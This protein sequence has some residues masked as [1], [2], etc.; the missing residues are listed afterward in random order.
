MNPERY[1]WRRGSA[2]RPGAPAAF[3]ECV[4]KRHRANPWPIALIA[5]PHAIRLARA[6]A[7][8]TDK[9]LRRSIVELVEELAAEDRSP[10][11]GM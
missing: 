9:E 4:G 5:E 7:S 8:V 10:G 2:A 3:F 6:L 11:D 1:V